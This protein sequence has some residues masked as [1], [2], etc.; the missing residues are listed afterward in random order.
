MQAATIAVTGASGQVGTEVCRRL[1]DSGRAVV[2]LS[3]ATDWAPAIAGASVVLHLAGA[4]RPRRGDTYESANVAT[5]EVV[6][7]AV[8]ASGA[9]RV[10]FLSYVGADPGSPN[11][12]L[13]TKGLAE[14]ALEATGVPVT[15]FRCVHIFGPPGRPG[16]TATPFIA[17]QGRRVTVPGNGRQLI[18]PLLLQDVVEAVV[19]ATTRPEPQPGTFE[20]AGPETMSLDQLVRTLNGGEASLRHVPAPLVRLLA[21]LSPA[22]TPELV[23]LLL[24]DNVATSDPRATA[25]AFGFS[26]HGLGEAWRG[27]AD[28]KRLP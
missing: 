23:D 11:A 18:A 3:R 1:A 15:I 10:V 26:L 5:S 7:A 24:Q 27:R 19:A 6:A 14:R 22:L 16:P 13:R 21:H 28:A 8:R 12:Y 2:P 9:G 17:R 20:L 4:L 25:E